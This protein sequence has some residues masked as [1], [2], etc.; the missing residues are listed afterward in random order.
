M[1]DP[2]SPNRMTALPPTESTN[3]VEWLWNRYPPQAY[4]RCI[5]FPLS[6]PA[7]VEMRWSQV[8][9]LSCSV[10]ETAGKTFHTMKAKFLGPNADLV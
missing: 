10:R 2:E 5:S 4:A 6:P 8:A 9:A 1:K 7:H 3:T